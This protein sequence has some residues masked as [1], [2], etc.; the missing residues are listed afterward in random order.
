[1]RDDGRPSAA[2]LEERRA[3]TVT[4]LVR[5]CA[6]AAALPL[7]AACPGRGEGAADGTARMDTTNQDPLDGL[8][9]EEL[10]RRVEPMTPEE[11]AAMGII[12]TTIHVT[13]QAVDDTI[14]PLQPPPPGADTA[15]PPGEPRP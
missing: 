2:N 15:P 14:P 5:L 11:A 6:L 12:D 13:E 1:V 9:A 4:R 7:L 8:S 3:M 10:Q